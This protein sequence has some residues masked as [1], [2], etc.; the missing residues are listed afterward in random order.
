MA[1]EL[2]VI[3]LCSKAALAFTALGLGLL[4]VTGAVN[5][6]AEEEY[7]DRFWEETPIVGPNALVDEQI[8]DF[9]VELR[10]AA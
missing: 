2:C 6:R 8:I 1:A 9:P 10:L 5:C 4:F 3:L 7:W